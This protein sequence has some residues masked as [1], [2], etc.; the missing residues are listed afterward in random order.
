MTNKKKKSERPVNP[1]DVAWKKVHGDVM[2]TPMFPNI[3]ACLYGAGAQLIAMFFTSLI[4][5]IIFTYCKTEW[6]TSIYSIAMV[7]FALYGYL[8]G[9]V[10]SR[11]LKFFGTTDWNFSACIS[12]F[13]LPAIITG[14]IC[15]ELIFAHLIKNP[16]RFGFVETLLRAFGWYTLNSTMCYIGAYKGY[17]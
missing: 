10:T 12:A 6:R 2:R 17:M 7:I 14:A 8:N 4:A 5:I 13:T 15:L 11:M 3:L 9:Y 1:E 16:A